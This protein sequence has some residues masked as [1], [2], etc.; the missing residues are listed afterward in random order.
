MVSHRPFPG[1]WDSDIT[2]WAS[3]CL[4]A[5]CLTRGHLLRTPT[6]SISVW[7]EG[8]VVGV[9]SRFNTCCPNVS[10]MSPPPDSPPFGLCGHSLTSP[11]LAPPAAKRRP[12][13]PPDLTATTSRAPPGPECKPYYSFLRCDAGHTYSSML[14]PIVFATHFWDLHVGVGSGNYAPFCH[15]LS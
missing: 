12:G 11:D 8:S 13:P 6:P 1:V 15:V 3:E 14:A 10:T 7:V 9:S 5:V 4:C 2:G